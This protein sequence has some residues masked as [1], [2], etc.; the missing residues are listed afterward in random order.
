MFGYGF[1][2]P[3][4]KSEYVVLRAWLRIYDASLFS[5]TGIKIKKRN[6]NDVLV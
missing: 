6:A 3:V 4:L 5:N 1:S 2:V